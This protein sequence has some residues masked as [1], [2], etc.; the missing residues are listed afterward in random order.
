MSN[1]FEYEVCCLG[2]G[3]VGGP[4]M[5]MIAD[6]CPTVKVTVLDINEE[7]IARWNS[8]KP[9]TRGRV[10]RAHRPLRL[11]RAF[12]LTLPQ[13]ASPSTSLVFRNSSSVTVES[14][15]CPCTCC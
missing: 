9:R 3:Y 5:A 2:A 12:A 15:S 8:G 11:T 13:T 6:K 10:T 4:T 1:E 14:K 7:R